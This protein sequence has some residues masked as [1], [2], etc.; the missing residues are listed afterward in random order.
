MQDTALKIKE[1]VGSMKEAPSHMVDNEYIHRGYR[2]G[3]S[4]VKSIF[5]TLFSIHNESINVWSHLLGSILFLV[6]MV[7]VV[8]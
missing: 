8:S 1:C 4:N 7:F 6:M 2:I 3:Y 5:G